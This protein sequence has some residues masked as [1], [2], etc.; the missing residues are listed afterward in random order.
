MGYAFH[1]IHIK[2]VEPRKTADWFV[3]AFNFKVLSDSARPIG[4]RFIACQ[5]ADGVR[6]M[7]SN[8]ATGQQLG[9]APNGAHWGLEHI[10]ITVD[11]VAAE[12]KRLVG[13]GAK[14]IS[15]PV[16]MPNG[17]TYAFITSP[18]NIRIEIIKINQ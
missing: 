9:A 16:T 6:M 11:D 4:D 2:A 3:K 10:A 7:V 14:V 12:I 8:A 5:S 15:E 13:L 18:D 1:H 17:P